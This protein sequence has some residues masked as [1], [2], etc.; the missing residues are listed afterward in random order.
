MG[1][2]SL[3]TTLNGINVDFTNPINEGDVAKIYWND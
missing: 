2:S 1:G 3:A